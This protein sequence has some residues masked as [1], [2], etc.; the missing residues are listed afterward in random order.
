MFGVIEV[1]VSAIFVLFDVFLGS[2]TEGDNALVLRLSCVRLGLNGWIFGRGIFESTSVK[3][4]AKKLS[5]AFVFI[6]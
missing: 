4:S 5:S 3:R 2:F 1:R 6:G